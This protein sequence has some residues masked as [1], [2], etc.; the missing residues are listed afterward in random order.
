KM[1][2]SLGNVVTIREACTHFSPKV[3]R[4]WLLGTHYRNPLSFG[5]EELKAAARG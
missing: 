3:V 4:F 2:K 5:E 1:S